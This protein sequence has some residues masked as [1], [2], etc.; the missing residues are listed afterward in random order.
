LMKK[1]RRIL[2]F[3]FKD[4]GKARPVTILQE[5]VDHYLD[6]SK[7]KGELNFL[8]WGYETAT[9]KYSKCDVVIFAGVL[10]LAHADVAGRIFAQSR[11]IRTEFTSKKLN[12]V[13]RSEKINSLYQA[14]SR[15]CCRVMTNGNAKAMDAYLFSFDHQPLKKDLAVAMPGVRFKRYKSQH[16][17]QPKKKDLCKDA[18]LEELDKVKGQSISKTALFKR[19]KGF[20]K[21]TLYTA[22]KELM[23]AELVF[24]WEQQGRTLMRC[25]T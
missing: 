11:D 15:G 19:I 10:T 21:D 9:N 13:V 24:D 2:I 6:G 4:S 22:L 1:G 8:T 5:L 14:L 17:K 23:E 18:I 7:H 20:T 16:L 12:E 25:S 3:T